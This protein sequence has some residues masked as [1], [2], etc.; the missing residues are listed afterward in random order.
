MKTIAVDIDDVL[1]DENRA[2]WQFINETYGMTHTL[3]DYDITAP[4]WGLLGKGMGHQ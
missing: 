1:A 4:Y 3:E 2:M